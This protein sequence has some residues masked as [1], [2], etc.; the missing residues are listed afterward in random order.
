MAPPHAA[1][2]IFLVGNRFA[3]FALDME[4]HGRGVAVVSGEA[5]EEGNGGTRE[6]QKPYQESPAIVFFSLILR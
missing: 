4:G 6:T 5:E 3:R 2:A 1:T